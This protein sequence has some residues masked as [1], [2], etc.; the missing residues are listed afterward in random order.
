MTSGGMLQESWS[1]QQFG[2]LPSVAARAAAHT[3]AHEEGLP[4]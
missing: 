3:A 4:G 2:T 1:D